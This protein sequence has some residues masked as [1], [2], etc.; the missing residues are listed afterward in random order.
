MKHVGAFAGI[1]SAALTLLLGSGCATAICSS[2]QHVQV[3]STPPKAVVK[4]NGVARGE[5]PLRLYLKRDSAQTIRIE[6]EGRAPYETT[7]AQGMNVW[8]FGNIIWGPVGLVGLVADMVSGA[9]Y[10]LN[11]RVI[12]AELAETPPTSEKPR[13]QQD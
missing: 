12:S 5:T 11:P 7:L 3:N 10:E 2:A 8:L 4:V 9:I 1:V 13:E 6:L